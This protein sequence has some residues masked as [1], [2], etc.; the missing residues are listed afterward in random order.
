[1][2]AVFAV[3]GAEAQTP[4]AATGGT[5]AGAA[6]PDTEALPPAAPNTAPDTG[7]LPSAA[8]S[9]SS[10]AATI[11]EP[12]PFGYVLGDVL[13]QRVLLQSQGHDFDAAQLPSAERAG[14]WLWRRSAAVTRDD[15]NHNWLILDYQIINAPQ[16]LMPVNLP[17]LTLKSKV[18]GADSLFVPEWPISVAPLTPRIAFAKGGLQ[19]LRPDHP[20]PTL[21]TARLWRQ[22]EIGSTALIAT[23]AAWLG[24]WLFRY[25]RAAASQPFARAVREVR[26]AGGDSQEAWL[27]LHRAFDRTAGRALQINTLNVLFQRAPCF[28]PQR[29]AIERFYAESTWRFFGAG[30]EVNTRGSASPT[31]LSLPSL[32]AALRSIEK[33]HE[34]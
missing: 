24:W 26:R 2:L 34:R 11:Q 19:D 4:G 15:M 18:K 8:P 7:T 10:A 22:L 21:P 6:A 12:R 17:A 5:P 27:A 31:S 16:Q 1:M 23:L 3:A 32:C 25:I 30:G 13:T 28:E 20:A 33:Q 14:L 29:S 9:N